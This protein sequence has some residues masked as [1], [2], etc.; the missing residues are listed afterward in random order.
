[1]RRMRGFLSLLLVF[2]CLPA[3]AQSQHAD[4]RRRSAEWF[5]RQRAFPRQTIPA[6]TR[7][8]A[9]RGLNSLSQRSETAPAATGPAWTMIGPQPSITPPVDGAGGPIASGRV[10]ALAVD[11][12]DPATVYLGAAQGG[13]WKSRDGGRTWQPLSDFEISL[14]I[15]SLAIDPQQPNTIYAGTGEENFSGDSYY[16]AGVLKSTDGGTTWQLMESVF[17]GPDGA[18]SGGAF[19]GSLAVHPADGRILLAGVKGHAG[20]ASGIYRS[21]DS[22]VTWQAVLPGAPGTGVVFDPKHPD[23][24]FAALGDVVANANNGIY[25]STDGGLHW[26][27]ANGAAPANIPVQQ[28]GR[29]SLAISA[30]QPQTLYAAIQDLKGPQALGIFRTND[31]GKTW[32]QFDAPPYC[33]NDCW[34]TNVIQVH[35]LFPDIVLVGGET[36]YLS[37]GGGAVWQPISSGSNSNSI[38][39]DLHAITFSA[40][41]SRLYVGSDGGAYS[42]DHIATTYAEDVAWSNLNETLAITQFYPGCSL[43]PSDPDFMLCGSQDNGAQAYTGSLSWDIVDFGDGGWTAIDSARPSV[44][45]VSLAGDI[46]LEKISPFGQF[47]GLLPVTGGINQSDD[48]DSARCSFTPP[49][50]LDPANPLRLYFGCWRV[51]QSEDGGGHWSVVSGDLG[52]YQKEKGY[53]AT[54]AVSP[55]DSNRVYVG[56]SNGRVHVTS[57]AGSG[58]SATW[59]ERGSGLPLRSITSL[60]VDSRRSDVAY[61]G[62]SG[63]S[64]F[65]DNVGHVFKTADGGVSW[66]D[67][68]SNLPNT[69]VNAIALDPEAAGSLFAGTDVGVF[70]TADG[71]A[72]W[73]RFGQGLPRVAV[74]DLQLHPGGRVLRAAT[75]GRSMWEISLSLAATIQPAISSAAQELG[76]SPGGGTVGFSVQGAGFDPGSMIRWNGFPVP[77][78]VVSGGQL[79]VATPLA[80]GAAG[81]ASIQV[82]NSAGVRSN[83][84]N[85]DLGA[86][87]VITQ[88]GNAAS[89]ASSLPLAP[90]AVASLFGT[91]FALAPSAASGT[92]WPSTLAGATVEIR[93]KSAHTS[94][95][96]PL[97]YVSPKQINFLVPWD[98]AVDVDMEISVVQGTRVSAVASQQFNAFSPAIYTLPGSTQG[99]IVD[100]D[101]SI[102][103]PPGPGSH[104]ASA[105]Q[106]LTLFAS[107]LGPSLSA[108]DTATLGTPKV[109]VGG[110]PAPVT[111]SALVAGT[112]GL[113]ALSFTVPSAVQSGAAVPVIL[114]AGGL[115]SNTATVAIQ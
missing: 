104:P 70:H 46:D 79:R 32:Q 9:L 10:T 6:G 69:P 45:Y 96:A 33:Y 36:F 84:F 4:V 106:S 12:R 72:S 63:F 111:S 37:K 98:A 86:A 43:H 59:T 105:G 66:T 114:S 102:A 27:P 71:G 75:H 82:V 64:G 35:P 89:P 40:D 31:G 95:V 53:I 48:N 5:Y 41:G 76:A 20:E 60:A 42:T 19:I 11:P 113:Y 52:T 94:E 2:S 83:V 17:A 21:A 23:T 87:P 47:R 61:V 18:N 25:V 16:G 26:A 7:V 101:G 38:H 108:A 44:F 14:A 99:W 107:G 39:Y 49:Y 51:Y 92:N 112:L 8:N 3:S 88:V 22:G 100:A 81:R 54:I 73:S 97:L 56:T 78:T 15:G 68:S 34:Y 103:G 55:S 30:S 85:V 77:T 65:D 58:E 115:T 24:T 80:V 93:N 109:A 13:V 67:I 91:G 74:M 57:N 90:G 62:F 50:V 1:M 28:A 110:I 29:I